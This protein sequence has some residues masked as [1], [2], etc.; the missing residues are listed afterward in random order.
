MLEDQAAVAELVNSRVDR[1]T[2]IALEGKQTDTEESLRAVLAK[3]TSD[4]QYIDVLSL[5]IARQ[6]VIVTRRYEQQLD[7]LRAQV[8]SAGAAVEEKK[9]IVGHQATMVARDVFAPEMAKAATQQYTAAKFQ[10]DSSQSKLQQKQAQ[11]DGARRGIFVGDDV[12]DL[13]AMIQKKRDM[14]LDVQRLAI[15]QA[16]VTAA[17]RDQ[18][19]LLSAEQL[20]LASLERAV[21]TAPGPGEVLDVGASI[22][23]HVA[24]GDTLARMVNCDSSFVV[25]IFSYRQGVNLAVGTRVTIDAGSTGVR[26]GT[27]VQ[28]LPKTSDKVDETYAMPFPQTERRE[29]YVMVKP[30][31]PLRRVIDGSHGQ[32]DIGQWVTVTRENGWVPSFSVLWRTAGTGLFDGAR[33]VLTVWSGNQAAAYSKPWGTLAERRI[34][35]KVASATADL[36]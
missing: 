21:V 20:R 30:D 15:E 4:A 23:R 11:L 26:G 8:G 5:E 32:C 9:Q 29:L 6:S 28:V 17:V 33:T 31:S 3:R 19:K 14:E 7:E 13:A 10:E 25:A 22:G 2:L 35:S 12:H 24:A 34:D 1:T 18:G 16:Q 27:V 36:H